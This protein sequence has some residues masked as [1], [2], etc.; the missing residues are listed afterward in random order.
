MKPD[1][2]FFIIIYLNVFL[3]TEDSQ[4]RPSFCGL[5]PSITVSKALLPYYPGFI[6]MIINLPFINLTYNLRNL[7][8][9]L[10][11]SFYKCPQIF[12]TLA[13]LL[14]VFHSP[15]EYHITVLKLDT[16]ST[17]LEITRVYGKQDSLP[18]LRNRSARP[19]ATPTEHSSYP[20]NLIP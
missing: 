5:Q 13:V 9:H 16:F 4:K 17:S 20:Q 12:L 1:S 14:H 3:Y 2:F 19:Y 18:C 15:L 10:D 7:F 11:P 6:I 8:S